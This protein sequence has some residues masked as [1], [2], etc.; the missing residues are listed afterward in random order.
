MLRRFALIGLAAMAVSACKP[1]AGSKKSGPAVAK[2]N[3]FTITA[4]DFKARLDEQSPFIRARYTT[5]ERK[6][7]FLDNLVRFEVLAREA[8]KQGL[9]KDPDVQMTLK[10]IMVQ[11][12]V[13]KSFQDTSGA[14]QIPDAEL[15]TY[16]DE[17]KA[18]YFRPKKIRVA[19]VVFNA[20]A[21]TP[22]RAKKLALAKKA[23]AKL[24]LEEKK[25]TLAFAQVVNEFSEDQATKATSGDL[26]F[27]SQEEL[28][29]AYSKELADAVF[30]L[31]AGETSGVIET[32][33][34][35]FIA[36]A[37][38]QQEELNRSFEQVKTQIANKL[39]RER[40][41]KEFDEWQKRLKEEAK[42]SIDEKALEAVEVAAGPAGAPGMPGMMPGM[43]NPHGAMPMN[44][45]HA[46]APA[47]AAK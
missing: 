25:N 41:T 30:A 21:G 22:E 45:P 8:E 19:A 7:E 6:K 9:A 29:R 3:G 4:D 15:Q 12:L 31:K 37:T 1:A 27:K 26:N 33:Q 44:A 5:I 43:G 20:P 17:H 36:K 2:G 32:P 23:L 35:L 16:Y 39:Y 38:G 13:Q 18:D 10:K 14:S 34:A 46:P 28:E 11:K 42:V 40:K 24:K 47:P